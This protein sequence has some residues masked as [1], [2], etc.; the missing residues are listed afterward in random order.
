[1][2]HSELDPNK[3]T[4]VYCEHG[5]RSVNASVFLA[6]LGFEQLFNLRGGIVQWQGELEG[7]NVPP[8]RRAKAGDPPC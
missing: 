4:L 7:R 5:V 3:P 1:M 8:E 2:R 6:N